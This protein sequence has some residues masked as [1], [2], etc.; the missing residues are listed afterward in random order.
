LTTSELALF[1]EGST[2][3]GKQALSPTP[4]ERKPL[5]SDRAM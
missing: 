3:V 2:L 1:I 4:I 5:V